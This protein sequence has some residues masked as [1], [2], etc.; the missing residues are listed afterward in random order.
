MVKLGLHYGHF[1]MLAGNL[2]LDE[3]SHLKVLFDAAEF[4]SFGISVIEE[5]EGRFDHGPNPN[6]MASRSSY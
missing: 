1:L 3:L 5:E 2:V 4:A 6:L